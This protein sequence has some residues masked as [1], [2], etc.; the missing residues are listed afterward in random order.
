VPGSRAAPASSASPVDWCLRS[1]SS[2]PGCRRP[3]P[4]RSFRKDGLVIATSEES[5]SP[6]AEASA[7]CGEAAGLHSPGPRAPPRRTVS[8]LRAASRTP[9]AC[10]TRATPRRRRSA[11]TTTDPPSPADPGGGCQRRPP[12]SPATPPETS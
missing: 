12:S 11:S 8:V 1:S 6:A 3:R 2:R 4:L 10:R 5:D 7:R 9:S